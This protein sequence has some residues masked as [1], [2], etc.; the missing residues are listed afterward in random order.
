MSLQGS[1]R[2]FA[3]LRAA[4]I[5]AAQGR[6]ASAQALRTGFTFERVALAISGQRP[7][8]ARAATTPRSSDFRGAAILDEFSSNSFENAFKAIHL[9]PDTWRQQFEANCFETGIRG[10]KQGRLADYMT[11]L[12]FV[13]LDELGYQR[14]KPRTMRGCP[15]R[16]PSA[17]A[18]SPRRRIAQ[19]KYEKSMGQGRRIRLFFIGISSSI[20]PRPHFHSP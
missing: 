12:D 13:M 2:T 19:Q 10:G 1:A 17:L 5:L 6:K 7:A 8:V 11:R 15:G 16:R 20:L 3:L 4:S 9:H 18:C 14:T